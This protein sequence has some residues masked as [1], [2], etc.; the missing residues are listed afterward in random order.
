MSYFLWGCRGILTLITLRSERV[1]LGIWGEEESWTCTSLKAVGFSVRSA[2]KSR[3]ASAASVYLKRFR[4]LWDVALVLTGMLL[5]HW[6]PFTHA[7]FNVI[8][9]AISRTKRALTLIYTYDTS[10]STSISHVWT[11]TTQAQEKGTRSCA[12]TCVVPVHTWLM[13]VLIPVLVL[14]SYV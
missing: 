11:G 12:C 8:F 7:I 14:A 2:S 13:L 10:T 5:P 6:A 3:N 1:K 9:D 4:C